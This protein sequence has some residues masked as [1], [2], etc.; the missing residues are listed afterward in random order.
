[1][2]SDGVRFSYVLDVRN[3]EGETQRLRFSDILYK[4]PDGTVYNR[5]RVK[6]FGFPV[7]KV[8][9]VFKRRG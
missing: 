7:G 4:R 9:V 2:T 5:A 3:Q 8:E 6:K 1:M